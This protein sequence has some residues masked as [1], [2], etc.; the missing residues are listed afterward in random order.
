MVATT[1]T[2]DDALNSVRILSCDVDGVLTDGGLYF[3]ENGLELLRF[4]VQDGMGLKLLMA[5]GVVVC[6]ISQSNN[7]VIARR[8]ATLGVEH[9]FLG[10]EDKLEPVSKLA[11]DVGVGLE[12]VCHIAD[13]T[14][15]LSILRKVG[16][17]VTVQNGL[18]QVRD[19]CRFVTLR[20]GGQGAVRELCDAILDA[21]R[22]GASGQRTAP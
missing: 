18:P 2:C 7:K 21:Q 12:H 20:S 5:S 10:V 3:S 15:D 22:F 19:V 8:A 14:N 11:R 4:N 9:C 13:D 17:P 16:V 6:F 1:L